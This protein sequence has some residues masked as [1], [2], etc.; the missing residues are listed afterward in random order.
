[1]YK[2]LAYKAKKGS[3]NLISIGQHDRLL[4]TE[5]VS[6]E[7]R[8]L[9]LTDCYYIIWPHAVEHHLFIIIIYFCLVNLRNK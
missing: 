1:M 4:L 9:F 7:Q 3:P 6:D 2:A 5:R 8:T